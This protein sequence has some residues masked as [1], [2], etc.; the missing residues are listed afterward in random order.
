MKVIISSAYLVL[1]CVC[2]T[3]A[4]RYGSDYDDDDPQT[5]WEN[6][7]K[8]SGKK[9][10]NSQE[11]N[12]RSVKINHENLLLYQEFTIFVIIFKL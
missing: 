10:E 1:V 8:M 12:I 2:A 5:L 7:K 6:Y 4:Y 11:E 9:Y 3:T